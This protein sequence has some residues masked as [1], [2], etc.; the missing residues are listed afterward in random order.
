MSRTVILAFK[1][2]AD[3]QSAAASY[4]TDHQIVIVG[5]TDQVLLARENEDGVVWRSGPDADLFVM[6]A[7]KDSIA[8]PQAPGD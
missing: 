1:K 7:T 2:K 8:G 5:G 3:A 6:I 4:S